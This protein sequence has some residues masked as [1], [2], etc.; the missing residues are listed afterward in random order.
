MAFVIDS[1]PFFS[2]EK[3]RKIDPAVL[4]C[5]KLRKTA[6]GERQG[7]ATRRFLKNRFFVGKHLFLKRFEKSVLLFL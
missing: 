2:P 5:L 1:H 6:I 3:L 7:A 4:R